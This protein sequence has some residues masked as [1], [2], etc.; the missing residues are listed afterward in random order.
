MLEEEKRKLG[1]V[2][3]PKILMQNEVL[4]DFVYV[5]G[6]CLEN[7]WARSYNKLGKKYKIALDVAEEKE[8]LEREKKKKEKK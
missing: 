4:P 1:E 2:E 6:E 5:M 7:H 8:R 3:R